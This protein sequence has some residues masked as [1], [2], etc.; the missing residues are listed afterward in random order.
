MRSSLLLALATAP[1][2]LADTTQPA[3]LLV[4]FSPKAASSLAKAVAEGA[5]AAG[6]EPRTKLAADVTCADLQAAQ[7]L[8]LGSVVSWGSMA[9]SMKN[10]LEDTVGSCFPAVSSGRTNSSLPFRAGAAFA[11]GSQPATN[12]R[13][14]NPHASELDSVPCED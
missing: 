9:A 11:V 8:A 12:V 13:P 10:F 1:S 3:G 14:G 4:V 6:A 2:C 7:A 5:A